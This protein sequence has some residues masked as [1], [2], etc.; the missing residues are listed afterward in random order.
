VSHYHRYDHCAQWSCTPAELAIRPL[1]PSVRLVIELRRPRAFNAPV[2]S[3]RG[4]ARS[5]Q[6][7][8][9]LPKRFLLLAGLGRFKVGQAAAVHRFVNCRG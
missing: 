9:L 3:R 7:G 6:Y 8:E 2:A 1:N 4:R 5:F